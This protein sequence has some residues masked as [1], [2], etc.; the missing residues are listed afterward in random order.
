M[1]FEQRL[2]IPVSREQL[3]EFLLDVPRMAAC[4]P[5]A[6]NVVATGDNQYSGQMRVKLGPIHLTLHGVMTLQESDKENWRT[7]ARAEGKERRVGGGA[8]A[9]GFMT[10]VENG[11]SA[12]ELIVNGQVRFL[13]KLGEFGEPIIRKQADQ[14]IAGFARNVAA[15]F[16]K[17]SAAPAVADGLPQAAPAQ[18]R[19]PQPPPSIT[20]FAEP[21]P[22]IGALSGL[23]LAVLILIALPQPASPGLTWLW[24]VA[25]V[26]ALTLLGPKVERLLRAAAR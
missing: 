15:H 22:W 26:V 1:N 24:R 21:K 6:E 12:T 14:I 16:E 23:I 13:G 7:V 20:S 4:V 9:T 8:N 25:V 19:A 3:W 11:P 5:G 18:T 2:T 17:A 10:L